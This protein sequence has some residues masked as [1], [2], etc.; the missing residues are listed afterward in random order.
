MPRAETLAVLAG[1]WVQVPADLYRLKERQ[2]CLP[3][4]SQQHHTHLRECGTSRSLYGPYASAGLSES[5]CVYVSV[6][7]SECASVPVS[8]RVCVR[9]CV[10]VPVSMC[11]CVCVVFFT[12]GR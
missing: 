10:S 7:A 11:V 5:I 4:L 6:C 1:Q 2:Y 3:V 12:G 8:V 9:K